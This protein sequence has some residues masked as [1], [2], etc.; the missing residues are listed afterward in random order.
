MSKKQFKPQNKHEVAKTRS[1]SVDTKTPKNPTLANLSF[2]YQ[3]FDKNQGQ[4][5]E[6]WEKEG[7]LLKLQEKIYQ[8]SSENRITAC[9][10]KM[11]TIYGKF[12]ETDKTEFKKPQF[13]IP[14]EVEWG[15]IQ[16]IGGQKARVAGFI[17]GSIFYIV[18][19]DKE[20]K[21]WKSEK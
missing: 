4:S 18:F 9:Q 15:T 10:K 16:D 19:L 11:L 8:L 3:Y 14:D 6:D 21:F 2:S 7:L 13:S 20:H 17:I 12:P 1:E 5:F